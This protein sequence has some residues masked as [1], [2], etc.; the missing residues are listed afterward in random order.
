MAG[1]QT[2]ESA[3]DQARLERLVEVARGLVTERDPEV[4]IAHA[5]TAARELTGAR[6]AALGVLDKDRSALER[7]LTE[8]MD[9]KTIERIGER[10]RGRGLLGLLIDDPRPILVDELSHHPDS[11]GF[12][13]G[14]P[15]MKSFLGVPI[16]IHGEP[17]GNLYLTDKQGGAFDAIDEQSTVILAEW[18]SIAVNNA[19]SVAADRVQ[20]S[21]EAAEQERRK[22]ARELH[23][24]TLQNLAGLRVLLSAARRHAET[25]PCLLVINQ[26]ID[27]VDE[28]IEEM[29]RLIADLRP[30]ALDQLGVGPALSAL[31]D[32][33]EAES[34]VA[35]DLRMDFAGRGS[36]SASRLVPQ[37]EDTIYRL[38]QES[39]NNA[40]R[41]GGARRAIVEVF[42]EGDRI[43]VRVVDDG[44]GFDPEAPRSGYG[45]TGMRE[46]V[47][48]AGG[49]LEVSSG[50][51]GSTI[52]ASMDTRR[53]GQST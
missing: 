3:L 53:L 19:R 31:V 12:P 18:I 37:L 23:D 46:R 15:P 34:A 32:R 43:T 48:L 6:Y 11:H 44:S 35:I 2:A 42:E 10:P 14:H 17:W 47:A 26:S 45:L 27:R 38:I 1:M 16:K 5:L 33:V 9:E 8:G 20:L 24:E 22:W 13:P 52:K 4:V 25:D 50:A 7:F 28:T 40:V 30:A 41:H 49:E 51:S 29:R 21:F 39:L 36:D